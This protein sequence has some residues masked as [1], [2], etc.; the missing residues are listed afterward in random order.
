MVFIQVKQMLFSRKALSFQNFLSLIII[1]LF[2][3]TEAERVEA[4]RICTQCL[5]QV[6][7]RWEKTE[8]SSETTAPACTAQTAKRQV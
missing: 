7:E 4:E 8:T 3:L 5:L 1:C 6:L 2:C